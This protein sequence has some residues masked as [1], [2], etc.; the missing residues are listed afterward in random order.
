MVSRSGHAPRARG[1]LFG[2]T[3]TTLLLAAIG[4]WLIGVIRD[5]AAP[6]R[7]PLVNRPADLLVL[8]CAVAAVAIVSQWLLG[9]MLTVVAFG[10]GGLGA[11]A[12]R[13]QRLLA[14]RLLLRLTSAAIGGTVL[15]GLPAVGAGAAPSPSATSARTGAPGVLPAWLGWVGEPTPRNACLPD[16]TWRAWGPA[17]SAPRAEPHGAD[18][19]ADPPD[20]VLVTA[21][22]TLWDLAARR[23]PAG[24]STAAIDRSWRAWYAAN[25]RVVGADPDLIRPGQRLLP[26]RAEAER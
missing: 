12:R 18:D 19:G 8:A 22:D 11:V 10:P 25:R 13:G 9:L 4:W 14:P 16:P 20:P 3:V 7:G 6:T 21:G 5:L 23:L 24:S 2:A 1:L 17:P 26:P 15:A